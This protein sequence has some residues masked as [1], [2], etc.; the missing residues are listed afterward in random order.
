MLLQ[1]HRSCC[2]WVYPNIP[3]TNAYTSLS[4]LGL[5]QHPRHKCIHIVAGACPSNCEHQ[6]ACQ[7]KANANP[8]EYVTCFDSALLYFAVRC[9]ALFC[10]ALLC[11]ALL[12]LASRCVALCCVAL[13]CVDFKRCRCNRAAAQPHS[14]THTPP[15]NAHETV[16]A[17]RVQLR[18]LCRATVSGPCKAP[19]TP[20]TPNSLRCSNKCAHIHTHTYLSSKHFIWCARPVIVASWRRVHPPWPVIANVNVVCIY[21]VTTVVVVATAVI[22]CLC[23]QPCLVSL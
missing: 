14:T 12:C 9:S 11:V 23:C 7:N 6:H 8:L 10:F 16:K 19:S 20:T 13:L 18:I 17:F 1:E 3:D 15:N 2:C 21:I 4:R 22:R 5:P